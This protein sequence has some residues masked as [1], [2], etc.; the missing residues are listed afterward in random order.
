MLSREARPKQSPH[1]SLLGVK[2]SFALQVWPCSGVPARFPSCQVA[3]L[4]PYLGCQL[5]QNWSS[6]PPS[7]SLWQVLAPA[8]CPLC[9]DIRVLVLTSQGLLLGFL[10]PCLESNSSHPPVPPGPAVLASA[11]HASSWLRLLPVTLNTDE[12]VTDSKCSHHKLFPNPIPLHVREQNLQLPPV[13][14]SNTSSFS[15]ATAK[16]PVHIP[17]IFSIS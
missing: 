10:R 14:A 17:V 2:P 7:P 3:S 13:G 9:P 1:V 8:V 16:L 15:V 5:L 6:W 12:T 4:P 11:S